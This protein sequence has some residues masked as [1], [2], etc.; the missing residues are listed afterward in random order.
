MGDGIEVLSAEE[1]LRLLRTVPL[2]R[3]LFHEGGL[4]SVRLVNF[5]LD[6][7]AVVFR[8]SGGQKYAAALRGGVVGFEVDDI[9]PSTHQ[10]WTVTIVGH[11]S[12]IT[13]PTE[14]EYLVRVEA[15][16]IRGHRL[17]PEPAVER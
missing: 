9:D 15:E 17:G 5:A 10:G 13:D 8:T 4:P 12:T 16:S 7:G 14:L 1:C 6:G 3:L 11:V 2:G